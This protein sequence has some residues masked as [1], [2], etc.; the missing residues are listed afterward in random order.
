MADLLI[1]VPSRG[2][3]GNVE[4]LMQAWA[5][6]HAA[7]W[8]DLRIDIDADDPAAD[9]YQALERD[10]WVKLVTAPRWRP[11]VHKLNRAARQEAGDYFAL[12]FMGDDHVPRT[13]G[14]A[15]RYLETLRELGTG[16][17]YG[18]DG[19]R[20]AALPT[21]WALTSDIVTALGGRMVP[22]PVDHLYCD[23][24]ILDLGKV[25][26]CIRYLPDVLVEHMH[27]TAGKAVKDAQYAKVNGP[28]QYRHDQRAYRRWLGS[29]ERRDQLAAVRKLGTLRSG[30]IVPAGS[31]VT[32]DAGSGVAGEA[33]AG[34]TSRR[35]AERLTRLA[36]NALRALG[37]APVLPASHPD[38]PNSRRGHSAVPIIATYARR[39]EPQ[40]L[41]DDLR[42]NLPWVDGFVELQTPRTG[43]WPHEGQRLARQREM[44]LDQYGPCWV[45]FIDPDERLE[46]RAAEVVPAAVAEANIRDVLGFPLRELWTPTAWRADGEWAR[47]KPRRRLIHLHEGRRWMS[48]PIHCGVVPTSGV[49]SRVTLDVWL[50]HLKSIEP[51]NRLA[52]AEAYLA[53]DPQFRYQRREGKDWSWLYDE[54]GL[55]LEEITPDRAYS[56]VYQPGSYLFKAPK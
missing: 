30:G 7:V 20:G 47:K 52:R 26:G 16:I 21:Q 36:D 41:V 5:D 55:R 37:A 28:E 56:P 33:P 38:R 54:T 51:A 43:P 48:R 46:D 25:A 24:A 39:D 50:Y 49:L 32:L 17:V 53:A 12:G 18:N 8:A 31:V 23:N 27:Y 44:I 6:T 14:W 3:P 4:R 10:P 35:A 19:Q 45:L 2:R 22:A 15:Q 11:M 29:V 9:E 42:A 1:I 34:K 13:V 40:S